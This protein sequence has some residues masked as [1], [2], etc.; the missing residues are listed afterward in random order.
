MQVK[1]FVLS[2][3]PPAGWGERGEQE[4]EWNGMELSASGLGPRQVLC[5]C[6]APSLNLSCDSVV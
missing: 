6:E 4:Q 3:V 5:V 2:D 1:R